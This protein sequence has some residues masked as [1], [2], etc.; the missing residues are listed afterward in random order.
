MKFIFILILT[1]QAK[2]HVN[3]DPRFS[4]AAAEAAFN[5]SPPATTNQVLGKWV[6]IG[7]ITA[8]VSD[9]HKTDGYW[10]D[11][12]ISA[13]DWP[14]YFEEI[15]FYSLD[16]DAFNNSI[17]IYKESMVGYETRKVYSEGSYLISG[18]AEGL[19]YTIPKE[20]ILGPRPCDSHV[21]IR[22]TLDTKILI[23]AHTVKD[24]RCPNLANY[25]KPFRYI[26]FTRK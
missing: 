26:G 19:S 4:Y 16:T 8:E 13:R 9:Y 7:M 1:I 5:Q 12:K 17:L 11:G 22:V 24:M 23:V 2:A 18:S 20:K 21:E 14:G 3:Q 15:G 25:K 10:P 6:R